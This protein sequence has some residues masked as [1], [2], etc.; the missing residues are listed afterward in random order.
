VSVTAINTAIWSKV[1]ELPRDFR[2]ATWD[3]LLPEIGAS[4]VAVNAAL[5][6]FIA[7]ALDELSKLACLKP[8]LWNWINKRGDWYKEPSVIEQYDELLRILSG[9]SLKNESHLWEALQNLRS[10][11][12]SFTH[13][14]RPMFGGRE[15]T[16]ELAQTLIG[17][18]KEIVDW[19]ELLLPKALCRPKLGTGIALEV[20]QPFAGPGQPQATS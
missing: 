15:L 9:K 10:V 6:M 3:T 19:V 17:R 11:R 16:L 1:Q 20:T 4:I 8:D 14:G 18:A 12:N 13:E 2:P 5:E 7:W